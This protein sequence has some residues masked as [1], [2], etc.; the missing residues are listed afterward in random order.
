MTSHTSAGSTSTSAPPSPMPWR[1]DGQIRVVCD[2]YGLTDR[3]D[4]VNVI[5][6]WQERCSQGIDAAGG[7]G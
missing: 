4:V 1:R 6:W 3:S 7:E 2:A 5:L